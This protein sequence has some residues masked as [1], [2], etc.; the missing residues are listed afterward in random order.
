MES[1]PH[2]LAVATAQRDRGRGGYRVG[3]AQIATGGVADT[4]YVFIAMSITTW[5][6]P[7]NRGGNQGSQSAIAAIF[8]HLSHARGLLAAPLR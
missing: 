2:A 7:L 1:P 5:H 8:A 3:R 4:M 6:Q